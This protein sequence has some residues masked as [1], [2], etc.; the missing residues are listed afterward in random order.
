MVQQFVY[1]SFVYH[2]AC[3]VHI[4]ILLHRFLFYGSLFAVVIDISVIFSSITGF[5]K[6]VI[7]VA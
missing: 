2:D 6:H 5:N 3:A 4:E 1:F 7:R